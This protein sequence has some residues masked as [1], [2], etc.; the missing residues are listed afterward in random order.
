MAVTLGAALVLAP[1]SAAVAAFLGTWSP[2]EFRRRDPVASM[3]N[4]VEVALATLCASAV[5]LYL[6]ADP[7]NWPV[8]IALAFVGLATDAIVNAALIVPSVCMGLP[9]VRLTPDV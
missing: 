6:N 3:F 7:T 9:K 1:V 2:G 4:R 8:V 5:L